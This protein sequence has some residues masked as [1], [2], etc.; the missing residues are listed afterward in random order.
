MVCSGSRLS[1]GIV[2]ELHESNNQGG[3][4]IKMY[5]EHL[6]MHVNELHIKDHI[7]D[8]LYVFK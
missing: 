5:K 2:I 4:T 7:S 3:I 8:S 6:L 1:S